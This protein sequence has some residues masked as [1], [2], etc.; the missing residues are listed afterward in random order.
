MKAIIFDYYLNFIPY[1]INLFSSLFVFLA[2]IFFTAKLAINSE[3]IAMLSSGLSFNRM[4]V[5]YLISASIIAALTFALNSYIIPTGNIKRIEFENN[6]VRNR[7]T[8]YAPHIQL[9]VE[10]GLF[11]YFSS[12]NNN[13]RVG[14]GFSLDR[15]EGKQLVSRLTAQSITWDSAYHWTLHN[16]MI[17]NFDGMQETVFR[18]TRIDTVLHFTPADFMI[19]FGDAEQLTTPALKAYI[20]R[21]RQRG[22]G[23]IQSFEIEYYRRYAISFATFI[24]TIIGVSLS[25][26]KIK[27]GMGMNIGLGFL[28]S[29]SYI[30]FMQITSSFAVSGLVSPMVAVWIPN[31]MYLFIAAYLYKKAPN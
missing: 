30:L 4:V 21:Q 15:F 6:H 27:G 12:Y 28:L 14:S 29:F 26:R 20:E 7:R 31:M 2:V 5:P 17:R 19:S 16:C 10:P 22:I 11:A 3:I 23:N 25:S 13:N 18:D 8:I 1:F 9:E 24:L